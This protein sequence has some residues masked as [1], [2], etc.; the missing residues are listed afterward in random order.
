MRKVSGSKPKYYYPSTHRDST[1]QK[2]PYD[3]LIF[4]RPNNLIELGYVMEPDEQRRE[5]RQKPSTF[6]WM[7]SRFGIGRSACARFSHPCV[8]WQRFSRLGPRSRKHSASIVVRVSSPVAMEVAGSE[9]SSATSYGTG[10]N[11]GAGYLS[12]WLR[13]PD[14]GREKCRKRLDDR[15][16]WQQ[17]WNRSVK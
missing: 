10:K 7:I 13:K 9:I 6:C 16:S 3:C 15:R 12:R 1:F 11:A 14:G 4:Q 2:T 8:V 5:A 17:L